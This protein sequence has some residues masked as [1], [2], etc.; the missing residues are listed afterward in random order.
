LSGPANGI[1]LAEAERRSSQLVVSDSR[2]EK[3][4][5][6]IRNDMNTRTL[7]LAK[8]LLCSVLLPFAG[9][10]LADNNYPGFQC[11]ALSGA[12]TP[13]ANGHI[14]NGGSVTATV[15]CPVI[16]D[17]ATSGLASSGSPIAFVTDQNFDS[18]VCCSSRVKNTGQSVVAGGS[19][20]SSGTNTGSQ[21]LSLTNPATPGG[22]F[23]FTHRWLQC[24]IP[25]NVQGVSEIRTYRY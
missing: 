11:V 19:V 17:A 16:V 7:L 4:Q 20:C 2:N 18:N 1:A 6:R 14:Q 9:T 8:A 25:P 13:D 22:N 3:Q 24:S 21:S 15:L 23:T 10:A 5:T 12:V